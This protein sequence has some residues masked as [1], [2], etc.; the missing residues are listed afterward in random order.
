MLL[1]QEPA[2]AEELR[3]LVAH[4]TDKPGSVHNVI[5]G[6]KTRSPVIQARTVTG[7]LRFG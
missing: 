4:A 3:T 5:T 6:A 7:D 2:T 1:Q